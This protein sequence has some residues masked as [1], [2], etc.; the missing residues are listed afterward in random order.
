MTV[1]LAYLALINILA[2]IVMW[3]D[4]IK[5]IYR[6]WRIPEK[7]LWILA[8]IGGVFGIWFGMRA[9]IYHKAGKRQFRIYI[10]VIAACWVG[11]IC[12]LLGKL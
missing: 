4:K 1:L 12:V 11:I 2:Y 10:P 6:F 3:T 9:P 8:C 7:T 5:S